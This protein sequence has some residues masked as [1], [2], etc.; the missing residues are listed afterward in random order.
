MV[1]FV[2]DGPRAGSEAWQQVDSLAAHGVAQGLVDL[3]DRAAAGRRDRRL[4][5]L[6]WLDLK[7]GDSARDVGCRR[8]S[9]SGFG[10]RESFA[11][12]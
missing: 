7:P 6:R 9:R 10:V 2:A 5:R 3:L 4:A 11:V 8:S 12:R 1:T